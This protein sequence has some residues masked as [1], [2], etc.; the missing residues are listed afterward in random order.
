MEREWEIDVKVSDI[1]SIF[2]LL[3][4]AV[5]S[6]VIGTAEIAYT[7]L[8]VTSAYERNGKD[9]FLD[10]LYATSY[11]WTAEYVIVAG[12][13]I[14]VSAI[15]FLATMSISLVYLNNLSIKRRK[16]NLNPLFGLFFLGLLLLVVT[17]FS[18]IMLRYS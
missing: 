9:F 17:L 2:T 1:G 3:G 16:P 6:A 10:L 18:A 14:L 15:I 4:I 11:T 13:V 8:W 12:S 5:T 7:M